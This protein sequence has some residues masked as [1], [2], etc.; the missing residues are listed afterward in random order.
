MITNRS[1]FLICFAER[2]FSGS[3]S[4]TSAATL[5]EKY[6]GSTC[7]TRA[8]PLFPLR[9]E[10]HAS[11]TLFPIGVRQPT[12][13]R[14]TRCCMLIKKSGWNHEESFALFGGAFFFNVLNGI[15][16]GLNFFRFLVWNLNSEFFFEC[17]NEF[18]RIEGVCTQ[19]VDK[20]CF[21]RYLFCLDSQLFDYDLGDFILYGHSQSSLD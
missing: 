6:C 18:D 15:S 14:T 2:Y 9:T 17:H 13:V 16:D 4:L 11:S 7:V 8:V 20:R 12:P 3:K 10:A 21:R 19:I 5:E 1:V